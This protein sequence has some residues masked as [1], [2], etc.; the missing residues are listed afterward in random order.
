MSSIFCWVLNCKTHQAPP[1]PSCI[2]FRVMEDVKIHTWRLI[3]N[4]PAHREAYT[5]QRGPDSTVT[6]SDPATASVP[7]TSLHYLHLILPIHP[8]IYL[9]IHPHLISTLSKQRGCMSAQHVRAHLCSHVCVLVYVHVCQGQR[10]YV[11]AVCL[12]ADSC[13]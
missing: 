12:P 2:A 8:F 9:S 7:F 4:S 11:M 3:I 10:L 5:G 6:D 13:Y 1:P